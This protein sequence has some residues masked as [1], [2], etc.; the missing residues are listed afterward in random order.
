[1]TVAGG[2]ATAPDVCAGA[3]MIQGAAAAL[4]ALLGTQVTGLVSLHAEAVDNSVFP[5]GR[6]PDARSDSYGYAS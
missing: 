6:W 3:G 2:I 4:V 1:V 5:G